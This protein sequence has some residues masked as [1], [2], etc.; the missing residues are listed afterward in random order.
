M[1]LQVVGKNNV[2]ISE[3]IRA[4]AEKKVGKL[5]RYLP[6]LDEGWVEI[7]QKSPPSLRPR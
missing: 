7:S 6:T 3:T 4:Y 5:G 1:K 2:K